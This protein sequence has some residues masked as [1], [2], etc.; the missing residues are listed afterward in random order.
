VSEQRHPALPYVAL[1][2]LGLIWGAS[3]LFIKVA[4]TDNAMGPIEVVLIRSGAGFAALAVII[5]A[6]RRPLVSPAWRS[7]LVPFAVMGVTNA[8]LPWA[9]IAWGE[10]RITS[11]LASVLNATTPLFVAVLAY[12]VTPMERPSIINYAGVLLGFA[13]VVVL[14][15]PE[16]SAAGLGRDTLAAGA[17]L[18]ASLSY[19]VAILFQRRKLRGVDPY[20]QALGMLGLAALFALPF[21]APSLPS[22]HLDLLP[23]SAAVA[24]GVFGTGIATVLYFYVLNALGP[25]RG[26]G[27]TFIVP[28][29]AV[30]W[31][32]VLLHERLTLTI[33][34]GMLVI[35]VGIVLTNL[36]RRAPRREPV[37]ESDSAAA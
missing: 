33:V 6:M 19:A 4:V 22:V 20:Q 25:V 1:V 24:L 17:V 34:A 13:G 10:E 21:A 32:I 7:F 12:W 28:I 5:T 27:V 18:F 23:I 26:A 37:A 8:L 9:A 15:L 36:R 31:G 30:F 3:F 16:L 35:L 29:T 14:V 2:C 11:G